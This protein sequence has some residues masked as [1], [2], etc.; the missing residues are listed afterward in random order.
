MPTW[1]RNRA[2]GATLAEAFA[3]ACEALDLHLESL[4]KLGKRLP[5]PKHALVVQSV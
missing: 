3:S 4:E 1:P 2:S 5:K